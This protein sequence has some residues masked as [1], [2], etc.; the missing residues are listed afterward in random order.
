MISLNR[1][2]AVLLLAGTLAACSDAPTGAVI[3]A[4]DQPAAFN[5]APTVTVTNSS[6]TPLVNWSAVPNAVS[7]TV[8]L[9]TYISNTGN[10]VY[11]GRY[12]TTLTSTTGTSYLD[13]DHSYTGVYECNYPTELEEPYGIMYEYGVTAHFANGTSLGQRLAPIAQC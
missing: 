7:Y 8:S 12:F 1:F 13:T 5:A 3:S 10:G 2:V 11:Q 4:A 9:I 6:G